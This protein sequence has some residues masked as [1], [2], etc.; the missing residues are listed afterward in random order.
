MSF[1]GDIQN[2]RKCEKR[3]QQVVE[4][5]RAIPKIEDRPRDVDLLNHVCNLIETYVKS[6]DSLDKNGLLGD[7]LFEIYGKQF[8]QQERDLA[9]KTARFLHD[10]KLI[11]RY[12]WWNKIVKTIRRYF[13]KKRR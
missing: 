8:T 1:L 2:E 11:K 10:N 6:S 3:K 13:G 5:L 7:V 4:E 9:L 12:G